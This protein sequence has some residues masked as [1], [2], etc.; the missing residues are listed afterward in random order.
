MFL[1]NYI[2]N[3]KD[4][5]PS[6]IC[7]SFINIKLEYV[8]SV[9]CCYYLWCDHAIGQCLSYF[10]LSLIWG[11]LFI[12][13]FIYDNEFVTDFIV[14]VYYFHIYAVIIIIDLSLII[15]TS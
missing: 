6:N 4:V 11:L 10:I 2:Y 13:C 7:V 3:L 8:K 15:L 9:C 1:K 14:I 5:A 12:C